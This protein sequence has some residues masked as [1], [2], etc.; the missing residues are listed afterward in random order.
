MI[1]HIEDELQPLR[2]KLLQHPL[3]THIKTPNDLSVFM[4]YHVYAVWDFMSLLKALQ[5]GLTCTTLPWKPVGNP[6]VRYLIN[7]I[8]L[9]EETDINREGNRQSHY[10]MYIDAMRKAGA[11]I[12]GVTNFIR[13]DFTA[14]DLRDTIKKL[15]LPI[16]QF[17]QFTFEVIANGKMHEIAA[18]FTFGREDLIPKMFTVIIRNIQE[19]FP[20]KDLAD[21]KYY[22]DRHIEL[23]EDEH[24]PMALE[25]IRQLCGGNATKWQEVLEVSKKALE[26]RVALWDGILKE[27][28]KKKENL[29]SI[30]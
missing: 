7:E 29:E 26:V 17:L 15:P 10:E 18:A 22:F 3:Y 16:A 5:N 23:D 14:I 20:E 21:F 8:V 24:G 4:E 6:E 30:V 27:I 28:L 25:M 12:E 9:A 13:A 19:H 2:A 11:D 1:Q